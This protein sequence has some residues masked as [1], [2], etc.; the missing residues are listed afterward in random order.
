[1]FYAIMAPY[2]ILTMSKADRLV[3][4]ATRAERD[5]WT[6]DAW[7]DGRMV[8]GEATREEARRWWPEAFRPNADDWHRDGDVW[9]EPGD[10]GA[11]RWS[12]SPTG[13]SYSTL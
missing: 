10:D 5:A 2:G 7:W 4:F 6:D 8:R 9:E 1:M 3:R 13:G 12:G 11:Q